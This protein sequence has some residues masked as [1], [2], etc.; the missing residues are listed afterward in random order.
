MVA[1]DQEERRRTFFADSTVPREN[2]PPLPSRGADQLIT[3]QMDSVGH[4]LANYAQPPCKPPQ[5][6]IGNKPHNFRRLARHLILAVL[7]NPV[8]RTY[9]RGFRACPSGTSEHSSLHLHTWH[10]VVRGKCLSQSLTYNSDPKNNRRQNRRYRY[11]DSIIM[12]TWSTSWSNFG[13]RSNFCLMIMFSLN[14]SLTP[15]LSA[16]TINLPSQSSASKGRPSEFFIGKP[17]TTDLR[18]WLW[19][20]ALTGRSEPSSPRLR[21]ERFVVR[22]KFTGIP[23]LDT[24]IS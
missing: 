4:I 9:V 10:S 24:P 3:R 22:G 11:A 18:P 19:G 6:L 5:H 2:Q 15:L 16:V 7:V 21:T 1:L 14:R 20:A 8:P 12:A 13:S 17:R 23:A